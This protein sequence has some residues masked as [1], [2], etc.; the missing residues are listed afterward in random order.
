MAWLEPA[1]MAARTD[2]AGPVAC[3]PDRAWTDLA[4]RREA[5]RA[6]IAGSGARRVALHFAGTFEFAAALLGTW[7]AGATA[8]LAGDATEITIANLAPHADAFAGDFPPSARPR[9]EAP[10]EALSPQSPQATGPGAAPFPATPVV[11]FTSGTTGAPTAVAKSAADL[12]NELRSLE[13]AFG[14]KVGKVDNAEGAF[15][16]GFAGL[17]VLATV[18]HQHIYGLLFRCLWPLASGRPFA[19]ATVRYPE[20]LAEALAAP[21]PAWLVASPAFLKRLPEGPAWR[22]APVAVFSSGGPL[23]WEAAA[24][25]ARLFG[26]APLEI[27]GSTETGGIAWR[28]RNAPDTPWAPFPG[29]TPALDGEGALSL[30]ASPHLGGPFPFP[31]GDRAEWARAEE[32]VFRLLGRADRI[33][34]LEEKRLS[35]TAMESLLCAHPRVAEAKLTVLPGAREILGAVLRLREGD[36]PLRGMPEREALLAELRAH[37]SRGFERVLLP[38]RWRLVLEMPANAAGKPVQAALAALFEPLQGPLIIRESATE[39]AWKLDL[40]I[41]PEL[42]AFHGHFPQAPLLPGVVQVDWA[43]REGERRFGPLGVFRGLKS[44]KFQRPICPG[45]QVTL[46]LSH[47]PSKGG[48]GDSGD[49]ASKRDLAFAYDSPAGRHSAGQAVFA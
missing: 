43:L 14:P 31:T 29:V 22:N 24:T 1:A 11:L 2:L 40:D 5:W 32:R 33:V 49:L 13:A 44:L 48:K 35:L 20:E 28:Y 39:S 15:G 4:G 10:I 19:D 17:R 30:A 21:G 46:T 23:P 34:K 42:E 7:A 3:G 38:R 45:M 41:H 16:P 37:L 8:I 18:G 27:Y 9:I 25:S 12:G 6:A 36:L 47:L 26:T